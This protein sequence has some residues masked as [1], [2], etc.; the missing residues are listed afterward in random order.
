ME[1][2]NGCIEENLL[3]DEELGGEIEKG[4]WKA[5]KEILFNQKEVDPYSCTFFATATS[6]SNFDGRKLPLQVIKESFKDAVDKKIFTSGVGA[7][8]APVVDIVLSKANDY[9]GTQYKSKLIQLTPSNIIEAL[10]KGS[11]VVTG[12]K[13]GKWYFKDEQ[14]NAIIDDYLGG[15]GGHAISFIKINTEDD[16]LVKYAENYLGVYKN[17][18]I[19][20]DFDKAKKGKMLFNTGFYFYE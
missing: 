18:V 20:F 2:T 14:D 13:Y 17:N 9:W 6:L 12:I 16:T 19:L 11:P 3:D 1:I 7:K 4:V 15:E 5:Y 10:K 8:L